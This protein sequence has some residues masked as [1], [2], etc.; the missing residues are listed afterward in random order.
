MS[1]HERRGQLEVFLSKYFSNP[2]T[3]DA[4]NPLVSDSGTNFKLDKPMAA[5]FIVTPKGEVIHMGGESLP[6]ASTQQ[7]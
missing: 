6:P 5:T 3:R 2:T 7:R 1:I 4:E